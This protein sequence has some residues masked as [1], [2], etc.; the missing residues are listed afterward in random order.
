MFVN[1][2]I[3]LLGIYSIVNIIKYLQKLFAFIKKLVILRRNSKKAAFITIKITTFAVKTEYYECR[4]CICINQSKHA[5][6]GKNR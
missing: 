3:T 6:I 1:G 2:K 4:I 5:W